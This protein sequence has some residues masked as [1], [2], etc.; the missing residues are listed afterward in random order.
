MAKIHPWSEGIGCQF[1]LGEGDD[2]EQREAR[3]LRQSQASDVIDNS[4]RE[5]DKGGHAWRSKQSL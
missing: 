1:E 3:E 2:P 4:L 5:S